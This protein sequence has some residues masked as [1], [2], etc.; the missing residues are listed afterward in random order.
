MSQVQISRRKRAEET[1]MHASVYAV[2]RQKKKYARGRILFYCYKC[3]K[4]L[5]LKSKA[6]MKNHLD[7]HKKGE[8]N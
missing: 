2:V 4:T 3:K 8:I 6:A 5:I 1:C 7:S